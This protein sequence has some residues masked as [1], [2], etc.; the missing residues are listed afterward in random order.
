MTI[1][2][3]LGAV[4]DEYISAI[5]KEAENEIFKNLK[6]EGRIESATLIMNPKYKRIF[7]EYKFDVDVIFSH[8]CPEDKIYMVNDFDLKNEIKRNRMGFYGGESK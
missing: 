3:H 1:E 2:E 6:D 7:A 8:S 4:I 5:T